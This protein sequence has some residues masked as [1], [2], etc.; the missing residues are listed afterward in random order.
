LIGWCAS[1]GKRAGKTASCIP[2]IDVAESRF[3]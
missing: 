2:R 1:S 3:T